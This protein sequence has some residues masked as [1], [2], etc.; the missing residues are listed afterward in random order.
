M[1]RIH[2][3]LC[4]LALFWGIVVSGCS[5]LGPAATVQRYLRA[6]ESGEVKA[7]SEILSER[8]GVDRTVDRTYELQRNV[9]EISR[10]GGIRSIEILSEETDGQTARV[11]ARVTLGNGETGPGPVVFDLVRIDGRWRIIDLRAI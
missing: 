6:I 10:K 4:S 7:A 11:R 9:A 3:L 2:S 5:S 1:F 8:S